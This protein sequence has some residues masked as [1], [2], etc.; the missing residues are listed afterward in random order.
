MGQWNDVAALRTLWRVCFL[1][2]LWAHAGALLWG[3]VSQADR[4][5]DEVMAEVERLMDVH[6]DSALRLLQGIDAESLSGD[7]RRATYALLLSQ[8]FDKNWIDLTSDSII[9]PAVTYFDNTTDDARKALAHYYAGRIYYNA[10]NYPRAIV[11]MLKAEKSTQKIYN[12]I[13]VGLIYRNIANIYTQTRNYEQAVEYYKKSYNAFEIS[14]NHDFIDFAYIDLGNGY[15]NADKP[16]SAL[17]YLRRGLDCESVKNDSV[18][19]VEAL[20]CVA[21]TFALKGDVDSVIKYS[22]MAYEISPVSLTP[23]FFRN[24]VDAYM[25]K[26]D[27]AQA[28]ITDIRAGQL[29]SDYYTPFSVPY[30]HNDYKNAFIAAQNDCNT[31][32]SLYNMVSKQGVLN[33]TFEYNQQ[34]AIEE[35]NSIKYQR[36]IW[37]FSAIFFVVLLCAA[38]LVFSLIYKKKQALLKATV[39]DAA[40]LKQMLTI[41][42]VS[43]KELSLR[44]ESLL[45]D[46][47]DDIDEMCRQYS[48]FSDTT[49]AKKALATKVVTHL[50][51]FQEN[52]EQYEEICQ[53]VRE[54]RAGVLEAFDKYVTDATPKERALF[55]YS[56]AGFSTQAMAFFLKGTNDN[57]YLW[58]SRLKKKF[59]NLPESVLSDLIAAFKKD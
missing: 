52:A 32:D 53:I 25:S 45:K 9:A 38:I 36:M 30:G 21:T 48:T 3:C 24:W 33:A 29:L 23:V 7:R 54:C 47:I 39:L 20:S 26:D 1:A 56:A 49:K 34:C 10:R 8:A 42:A 50:R 35:L 28:I 15:A 58:K 19:Y 43:S 12:P 11:S 59:V 41:S 13:L 55:V 37:A 17:Y 22:K 4:E 18:Q 16:D 46:R 44:I 14:Q 5:A 51:A 40:N 31:L 57:I 2:V 6:P 27:A